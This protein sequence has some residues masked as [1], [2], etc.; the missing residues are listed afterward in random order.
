MNRPLTPQATPPLSISY[1]NKAAIVICINPM[2]D[3]H[4]P[5]KE[6]A[7]LFRCGFFMRTFSGRLLLL[8]AGATRHCRHMERRAN[9]VSGGLSAS[10]R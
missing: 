1:M 3:P 9:F 5:C 10:M 8:I 7:N 6:S 2:V 4:E